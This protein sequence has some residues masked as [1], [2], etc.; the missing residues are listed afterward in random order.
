M[1]RTPRR[2]RVDG[3]KAGAIPSP[4]MT[5][6]PYRAV[7]GATRGRVARA[8]VCALAAAVLGGGLTGCQPL[9][10][11][12]PDR[13][14]NPEKKKAPVEAEA[15]AA[16]IPWDEECKAE[17]FAKSTAVPRPAEAR[18]LV[19]TGNT[20]LGGADRAPDLKARANLIIDAIGRYK[21]A[22]AKDPYNAEAT[23]GL[24]VAYT[25]ALKKGCALALLKRLAALESNPRF[26][27]DARRMIDAAMA[28]TSFKAFR[29]DAEGALGR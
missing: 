8:L 18:P 5:S 4:A 3:A 12:K 11:G 7:A 17:F 20:A 27:D 22:L 6:H 21:G 1:S 2:R 25:K 26:A 23:Y 9:Y 29:K 24:A 14:R 19:E 28:D 10:S 15:P 13:M 16:P